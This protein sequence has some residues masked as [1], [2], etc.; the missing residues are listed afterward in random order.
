MDL[1]LQVLERIMQQV[2]N[3]LLQEFLVGW[4]SRSLIRRIDRLLDLASFNK[5]E[6]TRQEHSLGFEA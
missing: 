3:V 1:L 4:S 6:H 5:V 2:R